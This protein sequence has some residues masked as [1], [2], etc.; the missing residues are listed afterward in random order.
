MKERGHCASPPVLRQ[1]VLSRIDHKYETAFFHRSL[2]A[3]GGTWFAYRWEAQ[4]AE[5]GAH[6]LFLVP[7]TSFVSCHDW[8]WDFTALNYSTF[9]QTLVGIKTV[10]S[11]LLPVLVGGH[12]QL[13]LRM[14]RF[15]NTSAMPCMQAVGL[16][17]Y[18]SCR[19]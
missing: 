8:S 19:I 14:Q 5:L 1:P 12:E 3:V 10:D 16:A 17:Q 9:Y 4:L 6:V 2:W 11:E 13:I 7:I 18:A 15:C